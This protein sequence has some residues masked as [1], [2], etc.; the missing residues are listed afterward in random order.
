MENQNHPSKVSP[1]KKSQVPP[2]PSPINLQGSVKKAATKPKKT[3]AK[4]NTEFPANNNANIKE[5]TK[6]DTVKKTKKPLTTFINL[7]K[8]G[9]KQGFT[10][11]GIKEGVGS[12][13][14]Y[15]TQVAI[16]KN[17]RKKLTD[18]RNITKEQEEE[19]K[20]LFNIEVMNIE[21]KT[22]Y[23]DQY[24]LFLK[25]RKNRFIDKS[26]EERSEERRVGKECW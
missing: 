11:G 23:I 20:N 17:T 4:T 15:Y 10:K 5:K 1:V 2:Q 6:E 8:K 12:R 13:F 26:F 18:I 9:I 16:E 19:M 3:S 22:K 24:R 21:S 14:D 25:N 7:D